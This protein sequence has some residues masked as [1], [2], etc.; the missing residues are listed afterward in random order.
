MKRNIHLGQRIIL[1]IGAVSV[2]ASVISVAGYIGINSVLNGMT[3][4]SAAVKS[5]LEEAVHNISSKSSYQLIA[6]SIASATSAIDV[7]VATERLQETKARV[8]EPAKWEQELQQRIAELAEQKLSELK[9]QK[10]LREESREATE[11]LDK[12]QSSVTQIAASVESQAQESIGNSLA[13]LSEAAEAQSKAAKASL[14]T[15]SQTTDSTLESVYNVMFIRASA[16]QISAMMQSLQVTVDEDFARKIRGEAL[17]L[18]GNIESRTSSLSQAQAGNIRSALELI[19]ESLRE[20]LS[21]STPKAFEAIYQALDGLKADLLAMVDDSVFEGTLAVM[22][23]VDTIAKEIEGSNRFFVEQGK[24]LSQA[25]EATSENIQATLMLRIQSAQAGKLVG[26]INAARSPAVVEESQEAVLEL[27]Q[28]AEATLA[29]IDYS[30]K[31]RLEQLLEQ[32]SRISLSESGIAAT[33]L[34]TLEKDRNLQQISYLCDSS[35]SAADK[36]IIRAS[37]QLVRT[38]ETELSTGIARAES[39]KF[40]IVVLAIFTLVT[41]LAIAI[42]VPRSIMRPLNRLVDT[43]KGGAKEVLDA[44]T[45]INEASSDL[46]SSSSMQAAT[47]EETR[48]SLEDIASMTKKNADS[49]EVG[50]ES[51]AL[52]RKTAEEGESEMKELTAA[53]TEIQASSAEIAQILSNI[54]EIAFQTSI[55]A[56]NAAVEAASAGTAG[57]GFAVVAEEVKNLAARSAAAAGETAKKIEAATAR[58]VRGA[59][60]TQKVQ[61]RLS[62]IVHR[63][64][65]VDKIIS[66]I[67]KS[68]LEQRDGINRVTESITDIDN[69][70]QT[71]V[72]HADRSAGSATTLKTQSESM[73]SMLSDLEDLTGA[74]SQKGDRSAPQPQSRRGSPGLPPQPSYPAAKSPKADE[75]LFN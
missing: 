8:Q 10:Q 3:R 17:T 16:F 33:K 11:L 59:E 41:S 32:I 74:K 44:S 12:L 9:T 38:T 71:T 4:S 36:S 63:S 61:K 55:L 23:A 2:T 72:Q 64:Q 49:A 50:K 29:V 48:S 57:Q 62:E 31:A 14:S 30:D 27:L 1:A 65:E 68:S 42:F 67:S 18:A 56:L 5:N 54:D 35:L 73:N 43:L 25:L 15:L 26:Q 37:E 22:D 13:K 24:E 60:L 39:S 6:A 45:Q 70:T 7:E 47:F 46:A 53:M 52:A 34:A 19:R 75:I 21:R 28:Q 58:T 20:N 51:S 66:G 40:M 69:L